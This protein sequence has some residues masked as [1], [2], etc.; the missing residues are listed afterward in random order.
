VRAGRKGLERQ[1]KIAAGLENLSRVLAE[2]N[3]AL[4]K[5]KT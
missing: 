5:R 1:K 2:E 3:F 4:K